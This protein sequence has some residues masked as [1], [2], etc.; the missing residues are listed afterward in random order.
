V[1]LAKGA[2]AADDIKAGRVVR[3]FEMSIPL[4]FAYYIVYPEA[5]ANW[6]K[7]SAFR[8]WLVE[9]TGRA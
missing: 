5:K 3:L 8:A 7:I 9:Q 2:I 1:A 4:A 6:P